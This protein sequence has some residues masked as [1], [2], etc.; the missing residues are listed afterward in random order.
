MYYIIYSRY[1]FIFELIIINIFLN[2]FGMK[3]ILSKFIIVQ[4]LYLIDFFAKLILFT[5]FYKNTKKLKINK[6]VKYK[7]GK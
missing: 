1:F 4:I 5:L 6:K 3:Y 7:Y 2:L